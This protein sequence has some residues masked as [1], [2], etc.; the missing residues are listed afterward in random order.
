[1]ETI[2]DRLDILEE[3]NELQTE[4]MKA[5]ACRLFAIVDLLITKGII[6]QK[7]FNDQATRREA[8]YDQDEA[9]AIDRFEDT[10]EWEEEE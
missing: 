7:E 3:C 1:M 6:T 2:T 8:A 10:G 5:A 9:E 4:S